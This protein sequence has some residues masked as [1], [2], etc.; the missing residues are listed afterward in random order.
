[1]KIALAFTGIS[2]GLGRNCLH[3]FPAIKEMVIDAFAEQN[4]VQT[5]L[6]SYHNDKE[7]EIISL[8]KPTLYQFNDYQG[9]HQVTTY[10][11]AMEQ[12]RN[13]DLDFVVS[14]RFDIHFHK[15][16]N[17]IGLDYKKFNALFR[18]NGWWGSMHFTTDNFFAFPYFMLE[19]FI[20]SLQE[21]YVN[22]SRA[23]QMDLHQIFY[24]MMNRVGL[25]NTNIVSN[26][27]ELSNYN[28]FYSLCNEKWGVL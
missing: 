25:E 2:D 20:Q 1:M 3:C 10:I 26:M 9:S 5:Y 8:F 17:S 11:K 22:P 24:R 27:D 4:D 23:G 14:T 12:L 16:M 7:A 28:T 13:Q 19:P 18:E 15:K 21:L 6:T